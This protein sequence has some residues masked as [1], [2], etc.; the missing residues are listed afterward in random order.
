[1]PPISRKR[2]REARLYTLLRKEFLAARPLC[3]SPWPCGN[4]AT[5]VHH[6]AG[7][8]GERLCQVENF[9]ALCRSCHQRVTEHP[10]E[11]IEVGLSLPRIGG[12][13]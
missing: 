8:R 9:R 4:R 5:E 3:E 6:A 12:A 10:A 7:R 2:A 13:A 1:M 11:A